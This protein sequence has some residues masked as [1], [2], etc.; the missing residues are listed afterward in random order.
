MHPPQR[1]SNLAPYVAEL[2]NMMKILSNIFGASLFRIPPNIFGTDE[3]WQQLESK[4]EPTKLLG[5]FFW[6]HW[7]QEKSREGAPLSVWT[8]GATFWMFEQSFFTPL[9]PSPPHPGPG[10]PLTSFF[11]WSV[12]S[13]QKTKKPE[14]S[15]G[16]NQLNLFK[17][18]ERW[19][20]K[21]ARGLNLLCYKNVLLQRA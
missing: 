16:R 11:C 21:L 6:C 19:K 10:I 12:E 2:S 18:G 5:Q 14:P 3:S 15:S 20:P 9:C 7:Q 4:P 13:W 17:K 8:C 1:G